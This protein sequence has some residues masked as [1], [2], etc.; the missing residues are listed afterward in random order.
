MIRLAIVED[1][2]QYRDLLENYINQYAKEHFCEISV[3]FFTD[4]DEIVENYRCEYDIILMDI[5]MQ[6]MDGMTAA[7]TIRKYDDKV[8]LIFITNMANYAIKGYTVAAFDYIL[9]PITYYALEKSLNRAIPKLE[10]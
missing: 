4:G 3:R 2:Q 5:M 6:F 8:I 7:E 9:K 1:E 10:N